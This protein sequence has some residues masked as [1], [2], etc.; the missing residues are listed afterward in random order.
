MS[1]VTAKVL[2]RYGILSLALCL[3]NIVN[4]ASAQTKY[5]IQSAAASEFQTPNEPSNTLDG[6]L[7]TRW[8]AKGDGQWIQYDLD[9]PKKVS[10]VFVAWY[11]GD[12]RRAS[13]AIQVSMDASSWINVFNGQSRGVSLGFQPY[14]FK[15]VEARYVRV[16]GFGNTKNKWNSITEVEIHGTSHNDN[17]LDVETVTASDY[18]NA[19]EPANTLDQNLSTRWSAEGDGQW[20]WY[21]LGV[22]KTISQVLIAWYKGDVRVARFDIEV[23]TDG[24][25]WYQ[26]FSGASS[27]ASVTLQN[28]DFKDVVA[29][30]V[31]IVGHENTENAW[32]SLA[33]VEIHASEEGPNDEVD[34]IGVVPDTFSTDGGRF[35]LSVILRDGQG[36][37]ITSGVTKENFAFRDINVSLKSIPE[38][39]VTNGKASVSNID[40][41]QKE[42]GEQVTVVVDFDSSGSMLDN[43]PKRSRV[44]A[45]KQLV[46]H[47]KATD[48][49]AVMDFGASVTQGFRSS[50]L[51]QDFTSDK[52]LLNSAIDKVTASGGTPL[53]DSILDTL[54]QLAKEASPTNPAVVALTDGEDN[55]SRS[56]PL[57]VIQQAQQQSVPVFTVGLGKGAGF[58][59]LQDIAR[60]TGGTFVEA[61]NADDLVRLYQLIGVGVADGRIVVSGSGRFDPPLA[62]EGTYI[63]SGVLVTTLGKKT[64]DTPF[65]F[66]VE[67]QAQ[68]NE[69]V[70][71]PP[72]L[73]PSF[74]EIEH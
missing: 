37:I 63:V 44:E 48:R 53:Y 46:S 69:G 25:Q 49:A 26:V 5:P 23:S 34:I 14:N 24:A 32:N 12:E 41:I 62:E 54:D 66:P 58:P 67:V 42:A 20:I 38:D 31:R 45:G 16:V 47:L 36:G 59:P 68:S 10:Q 40:I 43:D 6:S 17:R 11:K 74:V 2:F 52:A 73:P 71:P 61:V 57:D 13:F 1:K 18:Y 65:S 7:G 4:F 60:E 19:H 8:S 64:F 50:R 70:P 39:I 28:Y 56:T 15:E 35:D 30:Y 51:L 33:E 21:D 22:I 55:R 29:R 3:I 9:S 27:G 72:P